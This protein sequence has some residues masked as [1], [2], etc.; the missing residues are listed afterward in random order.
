MLYCKHAKQKSNNLKSLLDFRVK[1]AQSLFLGGNLK[2]R[3]RGRLQ[4]VS[5]TSTT[6]FNFFKGSNI[7]ILPMILSA[8]L[9]KNTQRQII[10]KHE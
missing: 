2:R 9:K 5:I 8:V 1:I 7:Y 4:N 10:M 6:A 3:K